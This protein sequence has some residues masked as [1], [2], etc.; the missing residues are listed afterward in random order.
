[1]KNNA[2]SKRRMADWLPKLV[3]DYESKQSKL[4]LL[5][6]SLHGEHPAC[7]AGIEA[8]GHSKLSRGD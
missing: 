3:T 8:T 5:H 6:P 7:L 1:M 4:L 2:L